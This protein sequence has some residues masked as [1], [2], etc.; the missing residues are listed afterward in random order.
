MNGTINITDETPTPTPT[1]SITISVTYNGSAQSPAGFTNIK[2]NGSTE[3]P[4]NVGIYTITN[5]SETVSGTF[6]IMKKDITIKDVTVTP[7]D[8]DGTNI[9]N[10]IG[11]FNGVI[12]GDNVILTGTYNT[13][14]A[15][16]NTVSFGLSGTSSENYRLVDGNYKV[17]NS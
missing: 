1:T 13:M 14:N 2:Y 16:I 4:K 9:A 7:K 15:G 12:P 17:S 3:I 6:E 10:V 8:Y 5:D 11:T